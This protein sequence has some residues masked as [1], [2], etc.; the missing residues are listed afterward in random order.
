MK[1]RSVGAELFYADRRMDRTKPIVDFAILQT[2]LKIATFQR[3]RSLPD[4]EREAH[5]FSQ[6]S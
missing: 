4:T 3:L 2:R 6:E 1:I 5:S